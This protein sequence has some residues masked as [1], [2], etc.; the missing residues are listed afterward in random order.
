[1][2]LQVSDSTNHLF[3]GD[4]LFSGHTTTISTCCFFLNYYM[5]HSLWPIKIVLVVCCLIAMI[6]L[7]GSRA[8]YTVDVVMG[9]WISSIVFSLYH[10]YCEIPH[11]VRPQTRAFRRL[12]IFWTMFE[13]ERKVPA[14]RLP[15]QLEWPLPWPK[16]F[17]KFFEDFSD[18]SEDTWPGRM[19]KWLAQHRIKF[20]M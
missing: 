9:Y 17:K 19:A 5:P 15:N 7:I 13:T 11:E 2:G 8:H 20:H 12:F 1:M 14:G 3:C 6:C 16:S 4:M 10:A 18:Q